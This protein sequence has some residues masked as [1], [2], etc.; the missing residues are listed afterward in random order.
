MVFNRSVK[1]FLTV[2]DYGMGAIWY[3]I[4]AL[5]KEEI[6]DAFPE[7]E[8]LDK[9]PAWFDDDI[10]NKIRTYKMGDEPTEFLKRMMKADPGTKQG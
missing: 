9:E 6:T 3:Y 7:L 10:K 8:V 5:S 2:Y 4:F 1:K